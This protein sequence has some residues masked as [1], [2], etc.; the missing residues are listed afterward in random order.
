MRKILIPALLISALLLPVSANAATAKAGASCPKLKKTEVVGKKKF[1]CI[2]SGKKLVWN[3]GVAYV[4]PKTP[5]VKPITP[6]ATPTPTTPV[7]KPVVEKKAQEILFPAIENYA[8]AIEG[9]VLTKRV[10]T[11]GLTVSYNTVGSCTY[12]SATLTVSFTGVGSCSVTASQIGDA[13]YLAAPSVT[14]TFQISKSP[15]EIQVEP[16]E[17]QDLIANEK[18]TIEFPEFGSSSP[19]I[20]T[21]NSTDIC[22]ADGNEISLLAVG[23]CEL[24]FTKDGDEEYEEA[25]PYDL[26]FSIFVS[27]EPGEK[28]NPAELGIEVTRGGITV[29]LDG[30]NEMVSE[31]VCEADAENEGCTSDGVFEPSEEYD[32]Y[33]EVILTIFNDSDETW[34]ADN[35]TIIGTDDVEYFKT[36]VYAIDSLEGLELEPGDSITG[37][38][39]VLVPA[40][41]DVAEVVYL[42]SNDTEEGTFYF[43]V[44][45]QITKERG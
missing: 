5:A 42:Y 4:K 6:A 36:T 22:S 9:L 17:D 44:S 16:I 10:T 28:E 40:D 26:S 23:I 18:F 32:R 37:S 33:V 21:A 35:L 30:I 7:V 11:G 14:R 27:T 39:F 34:V 15:Q 31:D 12:N 41:L 3:K 1:T 24:T 45:E 38:Y 43:K 29:T 8:L 19:V 25:E 13:N 20:I 2:K